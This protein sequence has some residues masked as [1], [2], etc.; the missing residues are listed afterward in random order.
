M[1]TPPPR[2]DQSLATRRRL[3]GAA[4]AAPL[5]PLLSACASPLPELLG[6]RSP[7]AAQARLRDS[8]QAHGLAAYK[9]L[10]D[11][12]VSY[13]GQWRPLIGRLQPVLVDGGFRVSSQERLMPAQ[14]LVAQAHT[15]LSGSKQVLRRTAMFGGGGGSSAGGQGDVRIWFN[16]E[17]SADADARA[18]AALV[19]DGYSLFL[20]GPMVLADRNLVLELSG[21]DTVDGRVCDVLHVRLEPGLGFSV[22]ERVALL[23]DRQDALVRSIRFGLEGLVS[24]QGAVAEV[25]L[26]DHVQRHGVTWPTRF[27]ERLLRPF[28]RLPV[29]D[30]TLTGLDVNRGYAAEALQGPAFSGA[31]AAVAGAV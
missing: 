26:Y 15:G 3:V 1:P 4:L 17:E 16:G 2:T 8:A 25:E 24:T 9:A 29:H 12:N 23:I 22:R 20:L 7:P 5:L 21:T 30:W 19:V 27:Y 31:A 6:T 18:A 14:G 13:S 11:V 28:P 10:R